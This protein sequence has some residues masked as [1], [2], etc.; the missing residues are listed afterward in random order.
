MTVCAHQVPDSIKKKAAGGPAIDFPTSVA[1]LKSYN[2][3]ESG[4]YY[5]T[6]TVG[7]RTQRSPSS[8]SHSM[9]PESFLTLVGWAG[10]ERKRADKGADHRA[11]L[12]RDSVRSRQGRNLRV[13][14]PDRRGGDL[15]VDAAGHSQGQPV[16]RLFV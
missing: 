8:C 13:R 4:L 15:P 16:V 11:E 6:L 5:K 3:T 9:I 12:H 2:T 1:D 10:R 14:T 7:L